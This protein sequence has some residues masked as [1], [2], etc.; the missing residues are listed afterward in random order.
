MLSVF[1]PYF[2]LG[3]AENAVLVGKISGYDYASMFLIEKERNTHFQSIQK[4]S[5]TSGEE[6]YG[7]IVALVI[8]LI[9]D[10]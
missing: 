10:A 9:D 4:K 6:F 7:S 3:N 2:R 5:R 1:V 8:K